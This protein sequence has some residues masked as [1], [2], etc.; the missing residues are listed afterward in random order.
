M[1]K[2]LVIAQFVYDHI[3]PRL[4]Y[5][6]F[7]LFEGMKRTFIY[8]FHFTDLTLIVRGKGKVTPKQANVALRVPGG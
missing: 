5:I 3:Q 1:V 6:K 2:L 8:V 7:N 4:C